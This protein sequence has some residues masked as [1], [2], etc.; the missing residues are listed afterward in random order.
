MINFDDYKTDFADYGYDNDYANTIVSKYPDFT[1]IMFYNCDFK[2]VKGV[3]VEK[4][5]DRRKKW[6]YDDD[7]ILK[8]KRPSAQLGDLFLTI[9]D[10]RK[11]TLDMLYNYVLSNPCWKYWVT[12]TFQHGKTEK[13]DDSIVMQHWKVF[14]QKLQRYSRDVKIVGVKEKHNTEVGGLHLHLLV[15]DID[16][17]NKLVYAYNRD[18]KSKYYTQKYKTE[19]GD[20][21][22]NFIS[23]FYDYGF[24]TVVKLRKDS[25]YFQ[26]SNYMSKYMTEDL[27]KLDYGT[28]ALF[29]THNLQSKEKHICYFTPELLGQELAQYD[30]TT[31]VELVKDVDKYK[32]YRIYEKNIIKDIQE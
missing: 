26:I 21:V 17:D 20:Q 15:G 14:R 11:R 8:K 13:L 19:F 28:R 32:C 29:R 5:I 24:T 22:Y 2:I 12:L 25:N 6:F 16:F 31:K 27:G 9:E 7:G 30:L 10:S 23:S 18:P 4:N 1:E 3:T